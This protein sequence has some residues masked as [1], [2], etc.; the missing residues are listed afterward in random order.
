LV[1]SSEGWFPWGLRFVF[2]ARSPDGGQPCVMRLVENDPECGETYSTCDKLPNRYAR[3]WFA[4][5]DARYWLAVPAGKNS[6]SVRKFII[7]QSP[8]A[9]LYESATMEAPSLGRAIFILPA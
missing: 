6:I 3:Y 9:S 4:N 2:N 1:L 7:N 8:W 5:R